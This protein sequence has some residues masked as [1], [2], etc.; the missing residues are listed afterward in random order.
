VEAP[1]VSS[2]S[3][4]PSNTDNAKDIYIGFAK[5][6]TAPREGRKGRVIQDDPSKYPR[7]EDVGFLPGA[8]GEE[9]SAARRMAG[10]QL[11]SGSLLQA[12]WAPEPGHV[13]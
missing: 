5:D 7:K 6:D 8:T 13:A 10:Y 4:A 3:T 9:P 1:T 11:F 12:Q 2:T